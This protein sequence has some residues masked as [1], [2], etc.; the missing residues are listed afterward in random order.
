MRSTD[1]HPFFDRS[2]TAIR[3]WMSVNGRIRD[4]ELSRDTI[5]ACFAVPDT[6]YGL[7]TMYDANRSAIDAAVMRRAARGGDGV[8]QVSLDDFA[9]VSMPE[10]A[11]LAAYASH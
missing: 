10:L 5:A 8:L 11:E 2:K 9:A 7:I 4:L 6:Q 3:F 1:L